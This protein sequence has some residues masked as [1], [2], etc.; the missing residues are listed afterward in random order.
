VPKGCAWGAG[1]EGPS[2]FDGVHDV[3]H[4]AYE[5]SSLCAGSRCC[6]QGVCLWCLGQEGGAWGQRGGERG[7]TF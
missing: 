3:V 7:L 6:A 4:V 2:L 5:N 1:G